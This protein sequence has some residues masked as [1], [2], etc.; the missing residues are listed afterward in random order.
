[1]LPH[2]RAVHSLNTSDSVSKDLPTNVNSQE[3]VVE[4]LQNGVLQQIKLALLSLM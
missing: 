1:M 3:Q 2:R 4:T